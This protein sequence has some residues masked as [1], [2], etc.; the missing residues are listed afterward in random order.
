MSTPIN[1]A[2]DQ[3]NKAYGAA[4]HGAVNVVGTPTVGQAVG[5]AGKGPV[6]VAKKP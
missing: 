5:I 6:Y 2:S 3:T 1:L 4:N